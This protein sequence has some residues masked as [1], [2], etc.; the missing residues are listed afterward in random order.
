[1]SDI[2]PEDQSAIDA[3]KEMLSFYGVELQ[4]H[5]S[6][7]LGLGLI[8]F[9]IVQAWGSLPNGFRMNQVYEFSFAIFVGIVGSGVIHQ[10][11]RLY[12]FGKLAS[13]LMYASDT[14]FN[15]TRD[16]WNKKYEREPKAEWRHLLDLAKVSVY[17]ESHLTKNSKRLVWW[18]VLREN[19][20]HVF[21]RRRALVG[22]F[23]GSFALSY[24]LLFG[25][26]EAPILF[27][28]VLSLAAFIFVA[29]FVLKWIELKFRPAQKIL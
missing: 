4:S 6:V 2:A 11:W 29:Y 27:E 17:S 23:L 24:A 28:S 14:G 9:A 21:L 19:N 25:S 22:G 8:I 5:A 13:A 18:T 16:A 1:L 15:Q 12:A 3:S 20:D 10:I 26:L 7:I